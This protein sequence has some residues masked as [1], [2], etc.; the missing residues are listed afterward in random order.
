MGGGQ[1][2]RSMP[3]SGRSGASRFRYRFSS[4]SF[5]SRWT[6]STPTPTP[7]EAAVVSGRA[8]H[9]IL[10]RL[11]FAGA[12]RIVR[13]LRQAP[14]RTSGI[15]ESVEELTRQLLQFVLGLRGP[16]V[17]LLVCVFAWGEAAF[18]LG[19][20]TPGELTIAVAGVLASRG[21]LALAGVAAA[22]VLGTVLG[23]V[24]G[25]WLGRRWGPSLRAWG[26]VQGLLGRSLESARIVFRERGEWA[27][28]LGTFLSYVRM[29][30][31]FLAGDSGMSLRRFLAFGLPAATVWAAGLA[32]V[33]YLLGESWRVLQEMAGAAAFLV[34]I[35]FLLALV[36]RRVAVW[37]ARRQDRLRIWARWVRSTAAARGIRRGVDSTLR[38]LGRRFEPRVARGLSLTLGF[39]VLVIGAGAAGLVLNQVQAVRGIALIDYPVLTWMSATRTE[40]AVA[41]ARTGL[42]P[43]VFP[44]FLVPAVLLCVAIWRRMGRRA[45]LRV[46]LGLLGSG[47]GA[48]VLDEYV[49]RAVV[50]RSAF[51]SVPVAVT[52]ALVV[53][54][55]A[56]W[57]SRLSWGRAVATAAVGLF[58]VSAVALATI[59]AGWAAPSGIALGFALGL[60]WSTGLELSARIG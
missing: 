4:T 43:L 47:L 33:G 12:P 55:T 27:I 13:S 24:T 7:P 50:P 1:P 21:Q 16:V 36:I 45:A 10:P 41:V 6:S 30:I 53:H 25:Y 20:I 11:A 19:L 3:E 26:P 14:V 58:L 42:Q 52:A 23:N 9:P 60:T 22:A 59:V 2:E 51:P 38:W 34:L 29:F 37:V 15:E 39:L 40:T 32:V 56:T 54:V 8:D 44:A 35:L 49:L 18:F 57:G 31:P 28:V 48:H 46:A 5:C 17:Y